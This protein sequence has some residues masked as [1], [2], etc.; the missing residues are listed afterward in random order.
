MEQSKAPRPFSFTEFETLIAGIELIYTLGRRF[1][2]AIGGQRSEYLIHIATMAFVKLLMSI[3]AFLRF[4]PSSKFHAQEVEFAVDLSSAS[5]M[6]RQVMEDAIAFF[7]L[8]EPNLAKEEKVFRALVWQ[9]HSATETLE[10]LDYLVPERADAGLINAQKRAKE[11]LN[12]PLYATML[13][14]IKND[15]RGRIRKGRENHVLHDE[16]ILSRRGIRLDAYRFWRKTLS[17]FAHFSTLSD[18]LM[19]QTT[20]DWKNSWKS[21]HTAAFCVANFGA[22][23]VAAFIETFPTTQLLLTAQE[24][25][26][27]A[28]LRSWLRSNN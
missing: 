16:E 11:L 2:D 18:R 17:N 21:F 12:E 28:N 25:A 6:A 13:E 27:L 24:Q 4:I 26:A 1:S 23:A 9:L 3:Q 7:Y 8:S 10:S 14:K 22:E 19:M 20:S 15:R 5:V